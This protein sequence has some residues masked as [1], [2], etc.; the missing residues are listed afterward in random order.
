MLSNLWINDS[1]FLSFGKSGLSSGGSCL[2]LDLS[3]LALSG[4]QVD[5]VVVK[6]P[7]REWSGINL[8]DTVLDKS[9]GSD[10]FVVGGVVHDID[11]SGFSGVSFRG[12][13]EVAFLESESSELVVTASD[14]DS[15]NSRLVVNELSVRY[16]SGFLEGSLLF[17]DWHSAT[18]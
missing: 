6:V 17:M 15:S 8:N 4:D 3:F 18:S 5:T 16:G 2:L 7:L 13:V 14:S 10:K 12:P 11:D 9:F 1:V